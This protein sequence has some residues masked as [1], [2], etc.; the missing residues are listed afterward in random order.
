MSLHVRHNLFLRGILPKVSETLIRN[1]SSFKKLLIHPKGYYAQNKFNRHTHNDQN[2]VTNYGS[3]SGQKFRGRYGR[4]LARGRMFPNH[5][6]RSNPRSQYGYSG[7]DSSGSSSNNLISSPEC[8]L[9]RC[10]NEWEKII[11]N[12]LILKIIKFGYKIQIYQ[13]RSQLYLINIIFKPSKCK[14]NPILYEMERFL[15]D[16]VISIL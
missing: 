10:Y 4:F 9:T 5:S 15:K 8:N 7:P 16:C 6:R 14:I 3:R 12:S 1:Q 2:R 11:T 13:P